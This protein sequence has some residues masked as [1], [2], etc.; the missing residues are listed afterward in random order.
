M[1]VIDSGL[2][3][4]HQL[5]LASVDITS[6]SSSRRPVR[7]TYR[8]IKNIDPADF[9]S[10]LRQSS[11]FSSPAKDADSFADQIESVITA[12]LDEVAPLKTRSRRPPK[13]VTRWLSEDAI[14]AKRHR[15]KMERKWQDTKSDPDR[16][17]YRRACRHA[18]KLINT[19]RQEYFREQLSSATDCRHRW[20]IAKSLLHSFKTVHEKS[21]DELKQLCSKFSAF[22]ISK[23]QSLKQTIA[24][25]LA[26]INYNPQ[27]G[28]CTCR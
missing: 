14:A 18:N 22:F 23:I 13:A 10:R 16:L 9:E 21:T 3:S 19:S 27:P 8:Q 7:F 24:A 2:A 1:R 26:S 12:T 4:D 25:T 17:A 11:L 20:Q 5:I 28:S 6:S 15:R